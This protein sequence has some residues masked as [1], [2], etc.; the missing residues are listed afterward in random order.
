M[1]YSKILH[2][3]D[4]IPLV[5]TFIGATFYMLFGPKSGRPVPFSVFDIKLICKFIREGLQLR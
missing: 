5:S 3:K 2:A 4:S 1:T